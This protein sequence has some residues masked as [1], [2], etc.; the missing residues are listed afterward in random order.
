MEPKLNGKEAKPKK[1]KS[2]KNEDASEEDSPAIQSNEG[3]HF[4]QKKNQKHFAR[5]QCLYTT[6]FAIMVSQME[7]K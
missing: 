5:L 6:D 2:K 7:R 4:V 3:S 1:L